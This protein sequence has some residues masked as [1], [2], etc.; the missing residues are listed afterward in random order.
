MTVGT[1]CDDVEPLAT[2]LTNNVDPTVESLSR[3]LSSLFLALNPNLKNLLKLDLKEKGPFWLSLEAYV[4]AWM[5]RS[6]TL[7]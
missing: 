2:L 6:T 3:Y 7:A 5:E 1:A 4:A